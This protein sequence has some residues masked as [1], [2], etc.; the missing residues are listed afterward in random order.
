MSNGGFGWAINFSSPLTPDQFEDLKDQQDNWQTTW[1]IAQA[2]Y[3]AAQMYL[4]DKALDASKDAAEKQYDIADRQ[5]RIAEEEFSRY[6]QHF[7]LCENKT[8]DEECARPEYKEDINSQVA[9]AGLTIRLQFTKQRELLQRRRS[10]YCVGAYIASERELAI[11]EVQA[12]AQAQEQARR[13]LEERQFSRRQEFFNRKLQLFNIGRNIQGN[14]L[15]GYANAAATY[16]V[17]SQYEVQGRNQFYGA[18]LSGLGGVIGALVPS[19]NTPIGWGQGYR[20][21]NN[22]GSTM[23][24]N[25]YFGPATPLQP[26]I[27]MY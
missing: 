25:G 15:T 19:S 14:S 13:F 23:Y 27:Q 11:A 6:K 1:A 4:A 12:I 10:R 20:S 7:A 22:I 5:Q 18:V 17:G 16:N 21:A 2:A 8:I 24:G 3:A 26:N 9:R